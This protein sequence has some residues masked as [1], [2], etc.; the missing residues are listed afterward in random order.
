MLTEYEVRQYK[1]DL[2]LSAKF[3][4]HRMTNFKRRRAITGGEVFMSRC[5]DCDMTMYV[6]TRPRPNEYY[7]VGEAVALHCPNHPS[8]EG[9]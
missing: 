1:H 7:A 5:I 9:I 4:G 2:R 3:R 8:Q 6:R